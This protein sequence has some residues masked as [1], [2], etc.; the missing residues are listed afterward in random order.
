MARTVSDLGAGI[1]TDSM[2]GSSGLR[3]TYKKVTFD[4]T[5]YT[6]GGFSLTAAELGLSSVVFSR[7]VSS[8]GFMF[9]YDATNSKIQAFYSGNTSAALA[10][11]AN[12]SAA[13]NGISAFMATV[14]V[15]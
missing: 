10:E 3:T 12:G 9:V 5:V 11:L 2:G 13:L 4:A 8:G 14:G 7:P 15:A 1:P 6:T